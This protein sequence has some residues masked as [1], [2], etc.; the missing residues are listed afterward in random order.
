M[1]FPLYILESGSGV[2]VPAQGYRTSEQQRWDLQPPDP[3][4]QPFSPSSMALQFHCWKL[5]IYHSFLS[6]VVSSLQVCLALHG[7]GRCSCDA[8]QS[9]VNASVCLVSG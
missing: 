4:L 2:L 1:I 5:F 6:T 9:C 3:Q 7:T 8:A